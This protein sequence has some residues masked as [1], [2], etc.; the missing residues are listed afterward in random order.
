MNT[1]ICLCGSHESRECLLNKKML[2]G[3]NVNELYLF[4][5]IH[6]SLEIVK[7]IC[8]SKNELQTKQNNIRTPEFGLLSVYTHM[9]P[10]NWFR[11]IKLCL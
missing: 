4:I 8:P 5:K 6:H 1:S 11:P 9:N 7:R 2:P 3:K 10:I